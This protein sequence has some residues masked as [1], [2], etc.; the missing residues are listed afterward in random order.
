MIETKLFELRDRAT[1]IPIIASLMRE[2]EAIPENPE[3]EITDAEAFLL[4]RA[5]YSPTDHPP[6]V[7]LARLDGG[8]CHY[9]VYG[10]RNPRT[11]GRAHEFIIDH[12]TELQSGDVIDV[13]FILGETLTK[14][15][16]E[17]LTC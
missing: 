14:K 1:F 5:G 2:Q 4:R 8:E 12:W 6:L 3:P 13:E 9:D 11:W 15:V 7:L 16:S 17:R 10:W